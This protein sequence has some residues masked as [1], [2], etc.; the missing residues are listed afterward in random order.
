RMALKALPR[1]HRK[2][3]AGQS[4]KAIAGSRAATVQSFG[5]PKDAGGGGTGKGAA[6]EGDK[7]PGL[8]PLDFLLRCRREPR[9]AAGSLAIRNFA[10]G[11]LS[12]G[13]VSFKPS[14]TKCS[15]SP[16]TGG[17]RRP[18]PTYYH[19]PK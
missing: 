3:K 17:C 11:T 10:A 5:T 7:C 12:P 1:L 6:E 13:H 2:P 18:I 8:M 19:A 15:R 14:P 16:I 4:G 9:Y